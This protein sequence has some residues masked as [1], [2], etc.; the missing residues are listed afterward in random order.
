MFGL[1]VARM[2]NL[3]ILKNPLN[4]VFVLISVLALVLAMHAFFRNPFKDGQTNG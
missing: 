3:D 1:K 4:W 2:L